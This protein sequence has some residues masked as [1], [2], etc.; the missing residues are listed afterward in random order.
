MTDVESGVDVEGGAEASEDTVQLVEDSEGTGEEA[1]EPDTDGDGESVDEEAEEVELSFVQKLLKSRLVMFG[2]VA[3]LG[4]VL[5]GGLSVAGVLPKIGMPK[6]EKKAEP[7]GDPLTRTL[8]AMDADQISREFPEYA[9][10]PEYSGQ[11]DK[12]VE[13]LEET[14]ASKLENAYAPAADEPPAEKPAAPEKPFAI[15]EPAGPHA[16][17]FIQPIAMQI[18]DGEEFKTMIISLGIKTNQESARKMLSKSDTVRSQLFD[19]VAELDLETHPKFSLP[20]TIS[21]ALNER[22]SA[23]MPEL[24]IHGVYLREFGVS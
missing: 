10:L 8:A 9:A 18:S 13:P 19:T 22:L 6:F 21:Q 7:E 3:V 23:A 4:V 5:L 14:P 2:G 24:V 12:A 20:G 17:F 16:E 1:G 15:I 11:D